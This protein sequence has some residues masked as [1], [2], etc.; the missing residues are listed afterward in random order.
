[1]LNFDREAFVSVEPLHGFDF[2]IIF[3]LFLFLLVHPLIRN[4]YHQY[5]YQGF[6][7]SLAGLLFSKLWQD[8]P[9][10]GFRSEINKKYKIGGVL[11]MIRNRP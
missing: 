6:L 8:C 2:T 3:T 4:H 10:F 9:Y 1:M 7:D 11:D 5:Q